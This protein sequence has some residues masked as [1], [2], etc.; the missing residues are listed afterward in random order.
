MRESSQVYN[1]K[2]K[3]QNVHSCAMHFTK[4]FDVR[5]KKFM[6]ETISRRS[7]LC[8]EISIE[9][10]K[11]TSVCVCQCVCV[12]VFCQGG[13]HWAFLMTV[14]AFARQFP[15]ATGTSEETTQSPRELTKASRAQRS[16]S[17]SDTKGSRGQ[18]AR[19][20]CVEV[21]RFVEVRSKNLVRDVSLH[22]KPKILQISV[23]PF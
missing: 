4:K 7:H 10:G 14:C 19:R 15:G 11:P 13:K 6:S 20:R 1:K 21:R 17:P 5:T 9:Q 23:L 18:F 12:C 16:T 2:K 3:I 22:E 8:K